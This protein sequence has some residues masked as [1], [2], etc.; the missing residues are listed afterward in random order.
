MK[1]LSQ[2]E[3]YIMHCIWNNGN[4][5]SFDILNKVKEER[6]MSE[7]SVR[8]LLAR[9]VK[10][11]AIFVKEKNGKLYSY[12]TLIDKDKYIHFETQKFIDNVYQGNTKLFLLNLI[13]DKLLNETTFK[14]FYQSYNQKQDD[15]LY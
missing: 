3:I 12:E 1:R 11:K 5:T 8:T 9:L 6:K 15:K 14:E 7:K 13:K 4:V 10:K 2:S